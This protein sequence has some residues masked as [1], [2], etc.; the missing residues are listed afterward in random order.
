MTDRGVSEVLGYVFVF[1]LVVTTVAVVSIAGLG[2][3][4][5]ARNAEQI[6]NAERAFDLLATNIDDVAKRGAPSRAT[7][8][9][10]DDASIAVAE[11]VEF[12][13]TA[14]DDSDQ[15]NN[16]SESYDIWPIRYRS[17][18]SPTEILYVSGAIMRSQRQSA[19][20][21]QDPSIQAADGKVVFPLIQT[22]T[23]SAVS[24]GGGT[25]RIRAVHA[26]TDLV[27]SNKTGLWDRFYVNIT[28]P[29]AAAWN[30]TLG[31]RE[32]FTCNVDDSGSTDRV[33]C[34]ATNPNRVHV[35][36]VQVDVELDS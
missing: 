28:T 30:Q 24:R 18:D 35:P 4:Q 34:K 33:W 3:L 25:V 9:R 6:N 19:F 10:L 17:D 22:R 20:V 14:I 13:I 16:I 11:P 21:L 7:E 31:S 23:R 29:R 27:A 8:M 15:S 12:N 5:D 1:S 32:A 36:L 2:Q 26:K